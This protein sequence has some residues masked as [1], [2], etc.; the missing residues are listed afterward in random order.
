MTKFGVRCLTLSLT[1]LLLG[2]AAHADILG[3][4]YEVSAGLA[5]SSTFASPANVPG[6]GAVITFDLPG[7][8]IDFESGTPFT[9][10]AFLA[11]GGATILTGASHSTDSMTNTLFNITGTVTVTTGETFTAGHDDGVTFIIGS[12]TVI[13][14]PGP[15]G[16]SP[17]TGT[18]TG[19]SGNFAFQLVYGEC[20]G[21]P[22]D[23][24]IS[25]LA[26]TS[27]PE[28]TS[29]LLFGSVALLAG[30]ALRRKLAR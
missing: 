11:S 18:Y 2:A 15:T 19:A 14:A 30:A 4:I 1:G 29:V 16:F 21:A 6:S 20:C 12:D 22:A 23:L 27:T 25:G 26:L 24:E 10:G 13:N 28:P 8:V 3:S 7:T 9:I 5:G 17:T